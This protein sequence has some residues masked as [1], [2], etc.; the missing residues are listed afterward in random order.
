MQ[1]AF[2]NGLTAFLS[3]A[4]D[5]LQEWPRLQEHSRGL[6]KLA[7]SIPDPFR[8]AVVGRMKTGKSTLINAFVG[9]PLA[10]ADVEEATATINVIKYGEGEQTRQFVAVWKDKNRPPEQFPIERLV[11]DWTGKSP[12]VIDRV[13]RVSYLEMFADIKRL[14]EFEIVDTPGTGSAVAEHESVATEFLCPE[15]IVESLEQARKADAIVYVIGP[16]GREADLEALSLFGEGR[17][18]VADPYNSIC[19][20]HK[21]DHQDGDPYLGAH[22]RARTLYEK[23]KTKVMTVLPVS[24]P[25]A[26][27]F[28]YAPPE[29]FEKHAELF[30]SQETR[31]SEKAVKVEG[32][33]MSD[34]RR[35]AARDSYP[36]LPLSSY[37]FLIRHYL[38]AC[39]PGMNANQAR[40]EC[41]R[42]S[43]FEEL[44]VLLEKRFFANA[45]IIKQCQLLRKAQ[46]MIEPAIRFLSQLADREK[47]DAQQ[48]KRAPSVLIASELGPQAEEAARRLGKEWQA[49]RRQLEDL[50]K[51]LQVLR[52]LYDP[53][54]HFAEPHRE[55][56]R[57]LCDNA[58]RKNPGALAIPELIAHYRAAARVEVD[59]AWAVMFEHVVRRLEQA[60]PPGIFSPAS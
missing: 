16:A 49:Q 24:G 27:A 34:P 42:L 41:M 31:P 37:Q 36:A 47:Q 29:F 54:C 10:V 21:W 8:V 50:Q 22:G 15:T 51:D 20:L 44:E 56:I 17:L 4:A 43:H 38:N 53:D 35:K 11:R 9:H 6:R 1:P 46:E 40:Q 5:L 60:C 30:Q 52:A 26:L 28:K 3:S 32:I 33:W 23:L 19:V 59:G 58:E 55:I 13:R 25:L 48:F 39:P 7:G 12:E 18:S 57:L 45:R 2:D 14:K